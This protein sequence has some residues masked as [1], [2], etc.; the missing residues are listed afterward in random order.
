MLIDR[1]RENNIED[2][3]VVGLALDYCV[4]STALDAK[5]HGFKVRIGLDGTKPVSNITGKEML[6]RLQEA[7]V[8]VVSMEEYTSQ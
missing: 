2:V 1:L 6:S 3:T 5:K 4:G 8:E 7:K